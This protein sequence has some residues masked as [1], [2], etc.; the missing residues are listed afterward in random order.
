MNK[1]KMNKIS[2][3]YFKKRVRVYLEDTDAGGIVYHASYLK[4]AERA[5]TDMLR[6]MKL[7]HKKLNKNYDVQFVVLKMHI[8]F[9]K[10]ANL[11]QLLTIKSFI[12]GISAVRIYMKQIIYFKSELLVKIDIVLGSLNLHNKPKRIPKLI[13]DRFKERISNKEQL[14]GI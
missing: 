9:K 4:Y 7:E 6:E 2:I 12:I 3:N 11:E 10:F 5:R 1:E 13:S 14:D 8:D